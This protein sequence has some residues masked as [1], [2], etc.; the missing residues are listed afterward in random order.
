MEKAIPTE[1]IEEIEIYSVVNRVEGISP[2]LYYRNHRINEG[3]FSDK[4]RHLFVN[5][6][7]AKDSAVTLFQ[8]YSLH[9]GNWSI[10]ETIK[11]QGR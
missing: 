10:N 9:I 5:Q 4:V 1:N 3:D 7:L 2:G 11:E 6:A 8:R